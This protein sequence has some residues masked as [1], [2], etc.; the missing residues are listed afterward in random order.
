M[1]SGSMYEWVKPAFWWL[2]LGLLFY[3]ILLL[4]CEGALLSLKAFKSFFACV[5]GDK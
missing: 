4:E 3:S 2:K 1:L 5:D